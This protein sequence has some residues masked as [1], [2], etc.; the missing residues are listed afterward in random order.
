MGIAIYKNQK[1]AQTA[2]PT[3]FQF[4]V[5]NGIV[6]EKEISEAITLARKT[7]KSAEAVLMSDFKISKEAIGNSC[8]ITTKPVL[9]PTTTTWSRRGN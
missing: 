5:S 3:K 6:S 9:S 7:G 2:K 8:P 4:L 1:A